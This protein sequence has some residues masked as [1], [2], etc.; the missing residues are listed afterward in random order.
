LVSYLNRYLDPAESLAE[1]LFGLIMVL[2]CTLG[3]S[4]LAGNERE[5]LRATLIAAL[6]CNIAWGVIDAALYVM[7]NVF[8]RSRNSS[9]LQAI[10]S[11]PDEAAALA[12]VR[13]TLEPRAGPYGHKEDREQ[14]YR[15]M[16][17][18]I[19]HGEATPGKITIGD[20]RGAVAVFALVVGAA[21]P[22]A[23]P[24]LTI[25]DPF[26]ALRV[27]NIVQV[28]LLFVVGFH[29]A[30]S[31]GGQAWLTG[32]VLMLS[33]VVLVGIAIALGG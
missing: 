20:I 21:I 7:G 19:A 29:W 25:G 3:A 27:A 4:L 30:R 12:I 33:G 22:S 17:K 24:F 2:T 13:E 28:A 5:S 6:G 10:R 1:I 15:S 11:A 18:V 16:Y 9:L 14:L 31:I 26:L 8:A 23:V 32:L